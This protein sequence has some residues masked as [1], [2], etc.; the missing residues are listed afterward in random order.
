MKQNAPKFSGA[1]VV[2]KV[3][4]MAAGIFISRVVR[5]SLRL[6]KARRLNLAVLNRKNANTKLEILLRL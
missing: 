4:A 2:C 6:C 1:W 3:C 5:S